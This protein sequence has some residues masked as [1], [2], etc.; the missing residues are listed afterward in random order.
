MAAAPKMGSKKY[1]AASGKTVLTAVNLISTLTKSDSM[2]S[3][4][5]F[6]VVGMASHLAARPFACFTR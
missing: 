4:K 2:L 1:G 6:N 5:V 3:I